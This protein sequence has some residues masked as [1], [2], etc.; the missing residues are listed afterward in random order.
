MKNSAFENTIDNIVG[1]KPKGRISKRVFQENKV[2]Q[3]FQTPT[4]T[5]KTSQRI[6]WEYNL[7][8]LLGYI[9]PIKKITEVL[10]LASPLSL[11]VIF[12]RFP[13]VINMNND[14]LNNDEFF[15]DTVP[16]PK[17]GVEQHRKLEWLK[18]A[19]DK[20]KVYLLS[21][22]KNPKKQWA[23]ER[24]DTANNKTINKVYVEYKQRELNKNG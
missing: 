4:N 14:V 15:A 19:I 18:G 2:C 20:G 12:W 17:K 22:K 23:H 10:L 21:R 1:N 5:T 8:V 7:G 11:Y 13:Y 6:Y 24:V 9:G 16:T 3:I